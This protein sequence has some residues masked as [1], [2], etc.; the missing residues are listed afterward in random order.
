LQKVVKFCWKIHPWIFNVFLQQDDVEDGSMYSVLLSFFFQLNSKT[1]YKISN[2]SPLTN[3][4]FFFAVSN[5]SLWYCLKDLKH[6]GVSS[7]IIRVLWNSL[8]ISQV[9]TKSSSVGSSRVEC[10]LSNESQFIN[11]EAYLH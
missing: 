5:D 7:L 4:P 11:L 2:K 9:I 3:R 6:S 8:A 1:T 10:K